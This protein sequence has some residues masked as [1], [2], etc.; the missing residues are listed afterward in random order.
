MKISVLTSSITRHACLLTGCVCWMLLMPASCLR[1][2][3][4]AE[5]AHMSPAV[6]VA[7]GFS[8]SRLLHLICELKDLESGRVSD[9]SSVS[10]FYSWMDG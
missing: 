10:G 1:F 4:G 7:A 8:S 6:S 9:S 3:L 5:R 2:P